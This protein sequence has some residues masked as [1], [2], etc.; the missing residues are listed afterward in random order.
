MK[1]AGSDTSVVDHVMVPEVGFGFEP[2]PRFTLKDFQKYADDFKSQYFRKDE[3]T[4]DQL[5]PS[6]ENIEGEY[7]R[8]VERPTEEIEVFVKKYGVVYFWVNY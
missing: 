6:L 5:E 7:W 3:K 4:T 2:G 8:M 1:T